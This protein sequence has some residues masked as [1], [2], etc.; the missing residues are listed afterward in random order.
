MVWVRGVQASW[1]CCACPGPF[2]GNGDQPSNRRGKARGRGGGGGI[3]A[4]NGSQIQ[5]RSNCTRLRAP[6]PP[7]LPPVRGVPWVVGSAA[8]GKQKN[9]G[10]KRAP[11]DKILASG[12]PLPCS[13]LTQVCCCER[14]GVPGV[15]ILVCNR[16]PFSPLVHPSVLSFPAA[17][18]PPPPPPARL[19]VWTRP[20]RQPTITTPSCLGAARDL[21]LPP[22]QDHTATASR[23]WLLPSWSFPGGGGGVWCATR[24]VGPYHRTRC[25]G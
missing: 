22:T 25:V 3:D 6:H 12:A 8:L 15:G 17:P 5:A 24:G 21:A 18:A 4:R 11:C 13:P 10:Q 14:L 2:G 9:A 16:P 19:F 23:F 7:A 1:V 20:S